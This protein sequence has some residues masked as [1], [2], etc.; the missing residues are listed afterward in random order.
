[1]FSWACAW[2]CMCI[3]DACLLVGLIIPNIT[4]SLWAQNMLTRTHTHTCYLMLSVSDVKSACRRYSNPLSAAYVFLL[5]L[6]F[7]KQTHSYQ[8]KHTLHWVS[9]KYK[10]FGCWWTN[11]TWRRDRQVV[12]KSGTCHVSE[13]YLSLGAGNMPRPATAAHRH[14]QRHTRTHFCWTITINVSNGSI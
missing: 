3:F 7:V 9:V 8:H 13:P 5:S 4:S 10:V 11:A 2:V 12:V 1:M 6:S 14:T